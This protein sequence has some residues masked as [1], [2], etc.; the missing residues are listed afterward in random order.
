MPQSMPEHFSDWNEQ[1]VA[2]HDPEAFHHHPRAIVRWVENARVEAALRL[3]ESGPSHRVLDTG[4]GAGN[5]LERVTAGERLGID[6]SGVM[7]ERARK[8]LGNTASIVQGDAEELPFATASF[9]RVLCSSVLSHVLHP[10]RVLAEA[11]RVLKPGGRLVVSVS[12]EAAIERGIRLARAL[13]FGPLLLGRSSLPVSEHVYS[14]EYH[15]H[16]F[17]LNYMREAAA[18]LPRERKLRKVPWIYPV[19][20]VALYVKE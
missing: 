16:H 15:L 3:L 8:R 4:C 1:M 19:H 13:L 20:L 12:Y 6:L 10:E 7:A 9:D 18:Q 17:D 5:V 14:S 11:Y 2:R